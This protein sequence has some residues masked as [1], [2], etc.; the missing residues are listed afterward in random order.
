LEFFRVKP[1]DYK[2]ESEDNDGDEEE[3]STEE[4]FIL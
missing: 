4:P 2:V 3:E 1:E